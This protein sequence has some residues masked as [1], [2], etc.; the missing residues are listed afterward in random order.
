MSDVLTHTG[1]RREHENEPAFPPSEK[2][3]NH[4]THALKLALS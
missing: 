3:G 4:A 2:A 1:R